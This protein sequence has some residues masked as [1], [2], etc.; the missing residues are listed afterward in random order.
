MVTTTW[1]GRAPRGTYGSKANEVQFAVESFRYQLEEFLATGSPSPPMA[2]LSKL[3]KE[4]LQLIS[5]R[6]ESELYLFRF[7]SSTWCYSIPNRCHHNLPFEISLLANFSFSKC[8]I[9]LLTPP[10]PQIHTKNTNS[11][12]LVDQNRLRLTW[13]NPTLAPS[14]T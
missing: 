9:F 14:L 3:L 8:T 7:V 4:L 1:D 11:S 10:H 2:E 6:L 13:P 12:P 5:K